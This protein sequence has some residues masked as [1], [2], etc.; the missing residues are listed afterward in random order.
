ML[1]KFIKETLKEYINEQIENKT[2]Y[3]GSNKSFDSF[4]DKLISTGEG[5]DLFGKGYY[6]TDNKDVAEFYAK[7][8]TKKDKI[9]KYDNFGLFKTEV[10]IYQDDADDYSDKN[11]KIN[12]FKIS[13]NILNSEEFIIDDKFKEVIINS[14]EKYSGLGKDSAIKTFNFLKNN[15]NNI[16]NFRGELEYIIKQLAYADKNILND[17]ISYINGLGY[18]GIK[19]RPDKDFEGNQNSWNYVIF[20]KNIIKK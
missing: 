9:K 12:T 3:H 1:N 20:D 19:Y 2:L 7:L 18:Q 6:F 5:S 4:D 13:G 11:K 10:P 14:F 8:K 15:K 16:N 17:I